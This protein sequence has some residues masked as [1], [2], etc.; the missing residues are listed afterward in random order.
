MVIAIKSIQNPIHIAI[1]KLFNKA[2]RVVMH[3]AQHN[4]LR[5]I[6]GPVASLMRV[7]PRCAVALEIALGGGMQNI[8]VEREEDGKNAIN[9]L[10]QRDGG[11]GTFLPLNTI[12]G[13]ELT[14][15][16][17]EEEAGFVGLASR[18]ASYGETVK[19]YVVEHGVNV[20]ACLK[21]VVNCS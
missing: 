15:H 13:S 10:K 8:V 4:T 17:M 11:R 1:T 2:V 7:E 9:F 6:H 3:A 19:V 18:L 12:C 16:G 20:V 5:G 14:E 21:S